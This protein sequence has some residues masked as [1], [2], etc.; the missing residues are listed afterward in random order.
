MQQMRVN[1][2]FKKVPL[3]GFERPTCC[4]V[5]SRCTTRR[6]ERKF[7]RCCC[8]ICF[9][10]DLWV[11]WKDTLCCKWH[12]MAAKQNSLQTTHLQLK[13]FMNY[14]DLLHGGPGHCLASP[15]G[16]NGTTRPGL[17]QRELQSSSCDGNPGKHETWLHDMNEHIYTMIWIQMY[18]VLMYMISWLNVIRCVHGCHIHREPNNS[19]SSF[20]LTVKLASFPCPW[21][22]APNTSL[23]APWNHHLL[24]QCKVGEQLHTLV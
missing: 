21:G 9:F 23:L 4:R 12:Q 24:Q 5:S 6:P 8:S 11:F 1:E 13:V 2:S 16:Q 18:S 17:S 20:S 3:F 19:L 14:T 10:T 15:A 7:F 22:P